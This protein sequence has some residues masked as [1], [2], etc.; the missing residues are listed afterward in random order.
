MKKILLILLIVSLANA[1][2]TFFGFTDS[3][4]TGGSNSTGDGGAAW[5]NNA[6]SGF[7][8]FVCPG[9]DSQFIHEMSC[10]VKS[11]GGT[12]GSIRVAIYDSAQTTLIAEGAAEITVSSTD[13]SWVGHLNQAAIT[14]NPAKIYGGLK[15]TILYAITG[16]DVTQYA[17]SD[18]QAGAN[19][20]G[21]DWSL[22][23]F[24]ASLSGFNNTNFRRGVRVGLV[25]EFCTNPDITPF[26]S[27]ICSVGVAC[28]LSNTVLYADSV[29]FGALPAGLVG[30]KTGANIG[31]ITGTPTTE[32]AQA[33]YSI[34]AYG[35]DEDSVVVDYDTIAIFEEDTN[36]V[37]NW[38]NLASDNL[39]YVYLPDS[40]VVDFG[41]STYWVHITG[42]AGWTPGIYNPVFFI[43]AWGATVPS[44]QNIYKLPKD[45]AAAGTENGWGF[46]SGGDNLH[47]YDTFPKWS[48]VADGNSITSGTGAAADSV[49]TLQMNRKIITTDRAYRI[50]NIGV[51]GQMWADM[52]SDYGTEVDPL[53]RP[54][55]YNVLIVS[56]FTNEAPTKS[57][58]ESFA[59]CT[60][61]CRL[62]KNTG[63]NVVL[64]SMLPNVESGTPP[65]G[66][67]EVFRDS[68]NTRLR[69]DFNV[70][71]DSSH[72]FL[73]ADGITYADI[74]CDA[75]ANS[76]IGDSGANYVRE[77]FF[78]ETHPTGIGY[79]TLAVELTRAVKYMSTDTL[80]PPTPPTPGTTTVGPYKNPVYKNPVF[81]LGEFLRG[82]FK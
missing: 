57:F 8:D 17:I 26:N 21:T 41:D 30:E 20:T 76:T 34:T 45:P 1:Q 52:I 29:V 42:G 10:W 39:M 62:A 31:R 51:S 9:I 37:Y 69:S 74:F 15:Y 61:Y 13:Y 66:T 67:I 24:P 2:L 27:V 18:G 28:T 58:G 78:D 22:N 6:H 40:Q 47:P 11:G 81:R 36:L 32:T 23:G 50:K 65:S 7:G 56:E 48:I 77:Y 63:Y 4:V 14:P 5:G 55:E 16:N 54:G 59:N 70:A 19:A 79:D 43:A 3:S 44:G 33:L 72:I 35:C 71:T 60:T 68:V 53:Y 73:P 38:K 25:A 46:Y 64:W 75:A 82:V 12:P 80:L 49:Y